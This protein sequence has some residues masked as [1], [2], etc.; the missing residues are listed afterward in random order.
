MIKKCRKCHKKTARGYD[1][2]YSCKNEKSV[3]HR[4]DTDA[5]VLRERKC[6]SCGV[7]LNLNEGDACNNC[8][9]SPKFNLSIT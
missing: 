2:C 1:I 9:T 6:V 8:K 7:D 3:Q 4:F 5:N